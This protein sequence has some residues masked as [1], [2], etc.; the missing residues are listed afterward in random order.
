MDDDET[1]EAGVYALYLQILDAWNRADG[2]DF[3]ALFAEDGRTVGFDGSEISGRAAIAAELGRIFAG[4]D[5]GAYVG[6]FRDVRRLGS[7]A[8]ILHAVAGM[9]P[10]G[11]PDIDPKLNAVHA[12]VAEERSG[13]WHAVLLQNTPAQFHG[14]PELAEQL[15]EELRQ[16][17]GARA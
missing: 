5:T 13:V 8:A 7:K 16:E 10:P 3:A 4:H 2:D 1:Y 15:T 9:V 12:L 14:R 17:L 6:K 11:Q